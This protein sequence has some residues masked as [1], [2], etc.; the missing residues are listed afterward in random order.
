MA[1]QQGIDYA[2]LVE[3]ALRSVVRDA[4]AQV[5]AEGA[6]PRHQIYVTFRTD[7]D[8]IALPERL[9]ARYPTEMTVVLQHEFWDLE[10]DDAGFAV[11]LSFDD[12]LERL[13]IPWRSVS[14]FADPGVEFG[15]Q[16]TVTDPD[17]RE[18]PAPVSA[19]TPAAEDQ[20]GTKGGDVVVALDR[21]RKK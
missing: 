12:Q 19:S 8:G 1:Q 13:E 4:I 17:L 9:R 20:P 6:P 2:G 5:A 15:L 16:F 10:V 7:H 11:T 14:V 3:S 21:F 18:R